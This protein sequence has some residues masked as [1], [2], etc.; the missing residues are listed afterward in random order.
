MYKDKYIKYKK[1]YLKLK[2][3]IG[4]TSPLLKGQVWYIDENKAWKSYK[5]N[6][7]NEDANVFWALKKRSKTFKIL[8]K[9][10]VHIILM[11]IM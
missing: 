8:K 3:Q 6:P 4:G 1:K 5:K 9:M 7:I 10:M 2:S 11:I